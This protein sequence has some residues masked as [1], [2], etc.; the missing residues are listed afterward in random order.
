MDR[1]LAQPEAVRAAVIRETSARMQLHGTP[2]EKDFWVCYLL[3]E[4]FRLDCVEAHLIFKG[5]TSLSKG[6]GV[7]HRFSEDIDLSIHA[8]A[9]GIEIEEELLGL[10]KSQR[11]NRIKAFYRAARRFIETTLIPELNLRLA[12]GLK[13]F[14][15]ELTLSEVKKDF[16]I[17][18]FAYP[19]APAR[20]NSPKTMQPCGT[21][22]CPNH[23][24]SEISSTPCTLLS[25]TPTVSVK[26]G[27]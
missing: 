27:G 25:D 17:L 5:G 24:I 12:A 2:V 1:F 20:R 8:S 26:A 19:K 10:S 16:H 23:P 15:W 9:F 22:S 3:R 21:F 18:H 11:D 6:Y 14:D 7:I 13:D 4:L